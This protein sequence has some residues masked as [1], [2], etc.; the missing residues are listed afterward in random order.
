MT[1]TRIR[2][3]FPA[4][5]LIAA[6]AAGAELKDVVGALEQGY[7]GLKDVQ[8]DFTQRSTISGVG[9]EQKGS[10]ELFIKPGGASPR[11]RFDYRK[12]EPQQ[13]ISDGKT[14][15]LYQPQNRQ[16]LVSDLR[17][18]LA[19]G[20]GLAVTYLTGLGEVSRDFTVSLA[21]DGRDKKGNYVLDLVPK[22]KNPLLAKLR[23][24]LPAKAVGDSAGK[25]EPVLFPLLSAAIYD[26]QGNTTTLDFTNVR[27]NKGLSGSIFTFKAPPGTEVINP[28]S[29][30]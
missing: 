22:K 19:G 16:V 4:L 6:S 10:G 11:F 7:R 13:I 5:L 26:S 14:V 15:W 2:L 8:A 3:F 20:S 23:L 27:T 28:G 25:G 24:T 9:R 21:G 18:L 29:M 1:M 12:P 17:E 30:K